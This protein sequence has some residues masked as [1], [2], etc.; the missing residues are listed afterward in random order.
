MQGMIYL[1]SHLTLS[2]CTMPPS[3]FSPAFLRSH[4]PSWLD[5]KIVA[6]RQ[7][8]SW[9]FQVTAMG[10]SP[11]SVPGRMSETKAGLQQLAH[12]AEGSTCMGA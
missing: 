4:W 11:W 6:A 10:R 2:T 3:Q 5:A 8:C 1:R 9:P 7:T 12:S